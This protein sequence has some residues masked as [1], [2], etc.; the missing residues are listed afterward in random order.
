MLNA[1]KFKNT[2]D[3]IY[4]NGV[5]IIAAF[6]RGLTIKVLTNINDVMIG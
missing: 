5:V 4:H 3:E 1:K 2:A 6:S